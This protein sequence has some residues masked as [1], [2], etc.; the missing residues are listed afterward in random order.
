MSPVYLCLTIQRVLKVGHKGCDGIRMGAGVQLTFCICIPGTWDA[1]TYIRSY[2]PT[3]SMSKRVSIS[4][5]PIPGGSRE[6]PA[7]GP[8]PHSFHGYILYKLR[9]APLWILISKL[10]N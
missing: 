9:M 3:P 6:N 7:P 10:K 5:F 1:S 4:V 8:T 2:P